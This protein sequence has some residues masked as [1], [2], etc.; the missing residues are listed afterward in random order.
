[1]VYPDGATA[2]LVCWAGELRGRAWFHLGDK[3]AW[4]PKIESLKV[5]TVAAS[6]TGPDGALR[7][8]LTTVEEA[9]E[10]KQGEA[11]DAI[12]DMREEMTR[13]EAI[14]MLGD[15]PERESWEAER[16]AAK[17]PVESPEG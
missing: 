16:T 1:V 8:Y 13:D 7:F 10:I 12:A 2:Q 6:V 4:G 11:R 14:A 15:P 9:P 5:D 17:P 3:P